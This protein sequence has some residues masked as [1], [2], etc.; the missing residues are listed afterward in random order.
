MTNDNDKKDDLLT[1]SQNIHKL[2]EEG[3][4]KTM[5]QAEQKEMFNEFNNKEVDELF[6]DMKV[7]DEEVDRVIEK[8]KREM[9]KR[10]EGFKKAI[11][12]YEKS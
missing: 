10:I 7:G 1:Q 3:I 9:K 2:L 8:R 6:S 4:Q 12:N 11:E 5:S